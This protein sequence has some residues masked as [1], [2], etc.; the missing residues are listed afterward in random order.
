LVAVAIGT[1]LLRGVARCGDAAA[2]P[3]PF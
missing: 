3:Q 2:D 1:G